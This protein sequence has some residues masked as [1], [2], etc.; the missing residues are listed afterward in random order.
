MNDDLSQLTAADVMQVVVKTVP[1]TMTLPE[2]EQELMRAKVSGFPVVDAGKLVG[3]VSQSDI[4]RQ[5][6]AERDVAEKTSDFYFDETG[7]HE[8]KLESAKEISDRIGERLEGL[9]VKDVMAK[10]TITVEIDQPLSEIASRFI[11]HH[12][13]R[14]PVIDQGELVGIISTMDLLRLIANRRLKTS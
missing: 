6:C 7:F 13:H 9:L 12:V 2:L 8:M 14:L 5:M 1:S 10:K 4:V 11:D 3:V